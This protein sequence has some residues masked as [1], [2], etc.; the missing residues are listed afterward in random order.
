MKNQSTN[1]TVSCEKCP[2][3][4]SHEVEWRYTIASKFDYCLE[5]KEDVSFL[6]KKAIIG[7]STDK[8][9]QQ[10]LNSSPMERVTLIEKNPNFT[11]TEDFSRWPQ[12][13][14]EIWIKTLEHFIHADMF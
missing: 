13:H 7:L 2:I 3:N 6:S 8:L 14:R 1:K 5:C 9:Y 12:M 11:T 4:H 10:F